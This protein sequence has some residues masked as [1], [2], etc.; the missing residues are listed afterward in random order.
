MDGTAISR[1]QPHAGSQQATLPHYFTTGRLVGLSKHPTKDV[2]P[3]EEIR[4]VIMR[5]HMSK[6]AETAILNRVLKKSGATLTQDM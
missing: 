5:P 3:L 2:V 6:V 1:A 4:V